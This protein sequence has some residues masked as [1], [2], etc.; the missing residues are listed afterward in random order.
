M[1]PG[2]SRFP[3][4]RVAATSLP[5]PIAPTDGTADLV[6]VERSSEIDGRS[7]R[8]VILPSNSARWAIERIAAASKRRPV[9]IH[10]DVD[11]QALEQV[12]L[13]APEDAGPG[14]ASLSCSGFS[15][16]LGRRCESMTPVVKAGEQLEGPTRPWAED[17]YIKLLQF[18]NHGT[19]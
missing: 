13:A 4:G 19:G 14:S 6:V 11:W 16:G 2:P 7:T 17:A 12:T 15:A 1:K 9:V 5:F 3:L 18:D 8:I 10:R